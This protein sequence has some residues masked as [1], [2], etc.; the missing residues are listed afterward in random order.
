MLRCIGADRSFLSPEGFSLH[1]SPAER[2][3]AKEALAHAGVAQPFIV[4]GAGTKVELKDWG[5]DR[6]GEFL[7]H[8]ARGVSPRA[9]VFIGSS[10]EAERGARLAKRWPWLVANL[11]G[12]LT[13][14]Q[15]AAVLERAHLFI[16]HDSGPMHLA[17]SVGTTT[18]ALFSAR[19]MP[20]VW[21]P[22]G[23]EHNVF[24]RNVPCR[25][26]RLDECVQHKKRCIREIEPADVAK[27][28][29]D[30]LRAPR[31]IVGT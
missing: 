11:C 5:E 12:Q 29:L 20:G 15:S 7:G 22:F 8:L 26:C 24:Y 21:F 13:P 30:R 28:A 1:L 17:A 19:E 3:E 4:A 23:Q 27:L 2:F 16:G 10:D 14:R 9:L 25:D 6:W 31:R 18:I